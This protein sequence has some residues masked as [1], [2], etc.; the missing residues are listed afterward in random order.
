MKIEITGIG[1]ASYGWRVVD[2]AG[3]LIMSEERGFRTQA[4]ARADADDWRT[5]ETAKQSK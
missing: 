2:T 1:T 5:K 3:N 4:K